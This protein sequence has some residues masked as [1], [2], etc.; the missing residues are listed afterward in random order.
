LKL[1]LTQLVEQFPNLLELVRG[2]GLILGLKTKVPAYAMVEKLRFYGLLTTAAEDSIVRI[3]PPLVIE[4]AH[5]E[6]ALA[7]MKRVC[8]EWV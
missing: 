5:V 8:E 6:E 4:S 7:I 1:G 3:V 2:Q